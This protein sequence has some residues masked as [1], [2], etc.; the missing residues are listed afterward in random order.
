MGCQ[1]IWIL[2]VQIYYITKIG[3]TYNNKFTPVTQHHNC[4]G[5][6]CRIKDKELSF[7]IRNVRFLMNF[8]YLDDY[9]FAL[10]K[11][12]VVCLKKLKY[13]ISSPMDKYNYFTFWNEIVIDKTHFEDNDI[14][15]VKWDTLYIIDN[16]F[17]NTLYYIRLF[18]GTILLWSWQRTNWSRETSGQGRSSDFE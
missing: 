11:D 10:E 6:L 7:F 1:S 14:L 3:I 18:L 12:C 8:V 4:E 2:E 9:I 13:L 16:I 15:W 5:C 17:G